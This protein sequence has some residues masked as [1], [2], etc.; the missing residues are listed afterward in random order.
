MRVTTTTALTACALFALT[1]CSDSKAFSGFYQEAGGYL[2]AGDF[3]NATMNNTLVHNG[4]LKYAV[5]LNERFASSVPT[6]VNFAF[7]SAVLD[8]ASRAVIARQAHFISQFPEVRFRV[9]G[10]TDLVGSDAANKRLGLRRAQ[11]VVNELA[12]AGI[13]KSRLEAMVS[14]GESQPIVAIDQPERRNRRTVTEVSGFVESNPIVIDSRYADI[15]HR[16]YIES[17]TAPSELIKFG[18]EETK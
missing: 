12:R 7:N 16:E 2:N 15:V 3:G 5:N 17:A 6:T 10:H 11:A 4:E 1:A 9:Y 13:S 18:E 14:Y 8:A